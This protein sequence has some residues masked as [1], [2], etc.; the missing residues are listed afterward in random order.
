MVTNTIIILGGIGILLFFFQE[1]I[2]DK[3]KL[4]KL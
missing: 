4:L 1:V 2:K 3:L